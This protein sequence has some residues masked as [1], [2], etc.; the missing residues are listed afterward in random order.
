MGQILRGEILTPAG[1]LDRRIKLFDFTEVVGDG[2]SAERTYNLIATVWGNIKTIKQRPLAI[3]DKIEYNLR[4]QITF[5]YSKSY[6]ATRRITYIFE[7]ETRTFEVQNW[8]NVDQRN[9]QLSVE[10]DEIES[11]TS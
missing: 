7:G 8:I 9:A 10:C 6:K 5:P 11:R 2:G 4:H 3:G 1:N